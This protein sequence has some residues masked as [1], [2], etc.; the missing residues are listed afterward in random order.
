[1]LRSRRRCKCAKI[2]KRDLSPSRWGAICLLN[3]LHR[4]ECKFCTAIPLSKR[5][6]HSFLRLADV[7]HTQRCMQTI[8]LGRDG[9][10]KVRGKDPKPDSKKSYSATTR[11][12]GRR[13]WGRGRGRGRKKSWFINKLLRHKVVFVRTVNKWKRKTCSPNGRQKLKVRQPFDQMPSSLAR[14]SLRHLAKSVYVCLPVSWWR[15]FENPNT[16]DGTTSWS[17][18]SIKCAKDRKEAKRKTHHWEHS[19]LK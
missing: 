1:M 12:W 19:Q 17:K 7:A 14:V 10:G 9:C 16:I 11:R 13:R 3:N 15:K 8:P 5:R 4:N 2:Y 18:I 6:V